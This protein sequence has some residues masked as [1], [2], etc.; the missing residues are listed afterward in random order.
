MCTLKTLI[1]REIPF[2]IILSDNLFREHD[3]YIIALTKDVKEIKIQSPADRGAMIP[4]FES[5]KRF[6]LGEA[7]LSKEDQALFKSCLNLFT[8]IEL[9]GNGFA[10]E[11]TETKFKEY[12]ATSFPILRAKEREKVN[13]NLDIQRTKRNFGGRQAGSEYGNGYTKH[14][15]K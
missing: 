10:Y 4:A 7:D 3:A 9:S 5:S 14:L 8:K 13:A 12:Y 1:E 15:Q 2:A 11:F 6:Y